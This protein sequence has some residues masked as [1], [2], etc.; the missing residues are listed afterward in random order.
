M[1]D[2]SNTS[3]VSNISDIIDTDIINSAEQILNA[4]IN[5]A[6][7]ENLNITQLK[8]DN[9]FLPYANLI[10]KCCMLANI[11]KDV[12][13]TKRMKRKANM[14]NDDTNQNTHVF[15]NGKKRKYKTCYICRKR[16]QLNNSDSELIFEEYKCNDCVDI[17]FVKRNIK[18]NLTGKIAI[19]TGARVKI[20]F[21]TAIRLLECDCKVIATSRFLADMLIRY[22]SHPKYETFK[23]LLILYALD[24]RY[25]KDIDEFY[26]YVNS[27]FNK[28]DILIHNAAQTI[29]RPKE[30]YQYLISNELTQ[31]KQ[32][33]DIKSANLT[34]LT[35][36]T[37]PTQT[38]LILPTEI[39][40]HL[41][42]VF[43]PLATDDK[44]NFPVG[45][46]DKNGEQVDLRNQ[47]TW[48]KKLGEIDMTE[49]TE[50]LTINTLA[51]FHM[52]Q[53]FKNL[54]AN[55]NDGAYIV[56]VSSMEGIFNMRFKSKCHP[57]TNMAK[58][59]LNMMTRTSAPDYAKYKIYMVSVDTGWITNEF[60]IG[61]K[62]TDN[63][64]RVTPLDNIDGACRIL[65]PIFNYFNGE[66]PVYGVFLK[67]YKISEW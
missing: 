41:S 45:L 12:K 64:D 61:H 63:H 5:V 43:G 38:E 31:F 54:L 67:D 39:D 18:A 9:R 4:L 52:N 58:S 56:N 13:N 16:E 20:G 21:E 35:D 27:N 49:L 7:V 23:H 57:H 60:P 24:L 36:S 3:N 2:T 25:Q 50:L 29:R 46:F 6:N 55:A 1:S 14:L 48:I 47:N 17:N 40:T 33:E 66:S 42:K 30:F 22:K 62:T 44:N 26:N 10:V 19:V 59:A 32:I 65:D 34:D 51:P 53:L 11:N 37:N 28:V 15:Y 8:T